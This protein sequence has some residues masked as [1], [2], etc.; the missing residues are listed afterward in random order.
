[1]RGLFPLSSL[2]VFAALVSKG[3]EPS[4]AAELP[5]PSFSQL[6]PGSGEGL[7]PKMWPSL[8][9]MRDGYQT[10]KFHPFE[11]GDTRRY[12]TFFQNFIDGEY[13]SE[14]SPDFNFPGFPL[15]AASLDYLWVDL[16]GDK[17]DE[18]IMYMANGMFCG[19]VGCESFVFQKKEG[20]WKKVGEAASFE[21]VGTGNPVR[22]GYATLWFGD[23][24]A[25]WNGDKY[26]VTGDDRQDGD[27]VHPHACGK[28]YDPNTADAVFACKDCH[29]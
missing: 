3:G 12:D 19:S 17:Q 11:K 28:N 23:M 9:A 27:H 8:I 6:K 7:L 18:V 4:V 15:R 1:M 10:A 20:M 29:T 16:N 22:S 14:Q 2:I 26:I 21:S 24:C 13:P 5:S 25:V